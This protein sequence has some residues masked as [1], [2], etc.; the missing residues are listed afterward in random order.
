[1]K[2]LH[3]FL[4]CLA[5]LFLLS[6]LPFSVYGENSRY[7][8]SAGTF[9]D[10]GSPVPVIEDTSAGGH[11]IKYYSYQPSPDDVSG[12][13][14]YYDVLG[15]RHA[16]VLNPAA[17]RHS[18]RWPVEGAGAALTAGPDGVPE[19]T[20]PAGYRML[21]GIDVSKHNGVIDWNRVKAAG[22]EFVFVRIA[23]RGYG[24]TGSLNADERGL[25]NLAGAKA[26]F[27]KVGVYVFSQAVN[28][29]EALEEAEFVLGLLEDGRDSLSGTPPQSGKAAPGN[30]YPLDLPVIFDPETIRMDIARTD[31]VTGAQFTSNAAA[32][33][34]RIKKAG[35]EAGIYSNM[36]WE[37]YYFDLSK[38]TKYPVWYADYYSLPQTPY[39]FTWWQYSEKGTVDGVNG[40]VDLNV[41]FVKDSSSFHLDFPLR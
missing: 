15:R 38:L 10:A 39:Q 27:L 24:T 34:E 20:A 37:D 18:Y 1:M 14:F 11:S 3:R 13:F 28:E 32:F 31:N 26:A 36:I 41:W 7:L 21:R 5:A 2:I 25:A 23:Y 22:I 12:D 17:P 6:A 29:A 16:A 19:V 40:T 30:I 33:C 8:A 35:Y 9:P 4:A